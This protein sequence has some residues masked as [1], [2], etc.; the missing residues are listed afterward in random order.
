M[1]WVDV[2]L[3]IFNLVIAGINAYNLRNAWRY[4]MDVWVAIFAVSIALNLWCIYML[5]KGLL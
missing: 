2:I 5:T 4:N 1:K 3:V